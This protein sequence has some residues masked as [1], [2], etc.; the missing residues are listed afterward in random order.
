M[1]GIDPHYPLTGLILLAGAIALLKFFDLLAGQ[2]AKRLLALAG[3]P[4]GHGA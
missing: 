2:S 1:F 4:D 3:D